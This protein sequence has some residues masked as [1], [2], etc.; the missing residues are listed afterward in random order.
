MT[1][2]DFADEEIWNR[3]E[4]LRC[5]IASSASIAVM[6]W[7]F[8]NK[9][10]MGQMA[11][12]AEDVEAVLDNTR[13]FFLLGMGVNYQTARHHFLP[14]ISPLIQHI[15]EVLFADAVRWWAAAQRTNQQRNKYLRKGMYK[16]KFCALY[17][18]FF[19][20]FRN[21]QMAHFPGGNDSN[22]NP[23]LTPSPYGFNLTWK[24]YDDFR[25]LLAHSILLTWE[26]A[27]EAHRNEIS[28]L[29]TDG[30]DLSPLTT[31][32]GVNAF[33]NIICDVVEALIV[34]MENYSPEN[35]KE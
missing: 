17:Q 1:E 34:P 26:G 27:S 28:R 18:H 13:L 22:D 15:R 5:L 9:P 29:F 14:A 20:G 11:A 30:I 33:Y 23:F 32:T 6:N 8:M 12:E 25:S 3:R 10:L 35:Q 4:S 2:R 21:K 31:D 16:G 7:S 19:D 24:E